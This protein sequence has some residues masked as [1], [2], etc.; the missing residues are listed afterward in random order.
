MVGQSLGEALGAH[1][2]VF[3]TL[4]GHERKLS[5]MVSIC[6]ASLQRGGKLLFCGNGGSAADSQHIAAEFTG[7]FLEDREPIAAIALTTDTSAIT[8]ISNDYSYN[9]V[10]SRQLKAL[11]KPGDVLIAISTSGNSE[12]LISA[13]HTANTLGVTTVGWLGKSGGSLRE[14]CELSIVVDSDSTARIQEAH[15]FIGHVFCG[16]VE[17]ALQ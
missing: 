16:M 15:I 14:T 5:D 13:V 8:C 11:A 4:S 10:F 6:V 12:N 1:L 9:Q 3:N 7:R 2:D 17:A